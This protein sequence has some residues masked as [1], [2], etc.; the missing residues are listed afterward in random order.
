[1]KTFTSLSCAALLAM[2][3]CGKPQDPSA[4]ASNQGGNPVTAPVDYLGAVSRAKQKSEQ[5]VQAISLNQ[6][7]RHFQ[8]VEGRYPK[9]LKELVDKGYLP[10][11]PDPP[12]GKR[13]LYHA[14]R[15][16]VEVIDG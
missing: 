2:A 1:M 5:H 11:L 8:A 10:R 6:S 14:D 15:G 4:P 13:F 7:V 3:G 16:E 9:T 12:H